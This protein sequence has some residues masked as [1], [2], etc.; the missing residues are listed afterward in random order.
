MGNLWSMIKNYKLTASLYANDYR[1]ELKIS[2]IFYKQSLYFICNHFYRAP[3]VVECKIDSAIFNVKYQLSAKMLGLLTSGLKRR[4]RTEGIMFCQ[5]PYLMNSLGKSLSEK[6]R[7][8][9]YFYYI[10]Q[11]EGNFK[12]WIPCWLVAVISCPAKFSPLLQGNV[13]FNWFFLY[14]YYS[15]NICFYSYE[16]KK[17][18]GLYWYPWQCKSFTNQSDITNQYESSLTRNQSFKFRGQ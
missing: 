14:L 7:L 13:A 16:Y 5:L 9:C 1:P 15:W 17:F 6:C 4:N 3:K 8:L 18:S 11:K 2:V 12:I 10:W